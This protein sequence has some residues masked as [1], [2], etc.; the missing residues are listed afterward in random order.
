[1]RQILHIL[2]WRFWFCCCCGQLYFD[3]DLA[4]L[5]YL[6][7][8]YFSTHSITAKVTTLKGNIILIS[9][10]NPYVRTQFSQ[11]AMATTHFTF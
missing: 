7:H 3:S 1:M 6:Q 5:I 2:Q 4:I 9:Y 8:Q 10:P 11:I